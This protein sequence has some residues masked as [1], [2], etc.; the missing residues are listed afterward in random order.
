[1]R[2][3]KT[4]LALAVLVL[5]LVGGS[6]YLLF[7]EDEPV[8][9]G[10]GATVAQ[11]PPPTGTVLWIPNV[12]EQDNE[13]CAPAYDGSTVVDGRADK[14][15]RPTACEP[16]PVLA[17]PIDGPCPVDPNNGVIGAPSDWTHGCSYQ[18]D[19]GGLAYLGHSVRG[20]RAG[21]FEYIHELRPGQEVMVDD[22]E[23]TV[24]SVNKFRAD[25]LPQ[26]L[27][28]K[29]H[30]SLI[31]CFMDASADAG[32]EITTNTVVELTDQP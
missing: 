10:N 4:V 24:V 3:Q 21:A 11:A 15:Y 16:V 30:F 5:V 26:R 13:R 32:G 12:N 8:A 1:M 6:A 19:K 2:H 14:K 23:Y 29:G 22:F 31:T 28:A 25:G 9:P 27:W 20:P 18:H 7:W 17:I